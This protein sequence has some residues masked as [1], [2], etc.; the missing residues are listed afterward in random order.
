MAKTT[1]TPGQVI[2]VEPGL[3]YPGIGGV[4]H[5]DVAAITQ[6]GIRLLSNFPKPLEV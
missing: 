2:T 1:L 5:E 6:G 4:R 3:Y